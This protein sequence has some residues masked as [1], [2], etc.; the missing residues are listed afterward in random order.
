MNYL[1]KTHEL[2]YNM[3]SSPQNTRFEEPFDLSALQI[4]APIRMT[5]GAEEW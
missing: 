5:K 2:F 4:F 1:R 3:R